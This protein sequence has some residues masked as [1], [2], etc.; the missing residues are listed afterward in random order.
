MRLLRL[1]EEKPDAA[2]R[3]KVSEA[4]KLASEE[5][6][7]LV[8]EGVYPKAG[9]GIATL[10]P[11]DICFDGSSLTGTAQSS[12]AWIF[13]LAA[14]S[15]WYNIVDLTLSQDLYVVL[16]GIHSRTA[17]PA[18]TN[19]KPVIDGSDLPILNIEEMY[20]WD[21]AAAY[22]TEPI[23]VKPSTGLRIRAIGTEARTAEYFGFIGQTV[24]KRPFLIKE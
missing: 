21:L 9:F 5:W 16:T 1:V 18:I 20:T 7:P 15:T 4:I 24:A 23:L 13:S 14:A 19:I 10:R 11:K 17:N 6:K 12:I 3:N 2:I 8:F 22:F